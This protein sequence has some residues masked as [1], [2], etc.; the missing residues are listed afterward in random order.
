MAPT[1]LNRKWN[2]IGPGSFD[3]IANMTSILRPTSID[4]AVQHQPLSSCTRGPIFP[5]SGRIL[6][7]T[8]VLSCSALETFLFSLV[9]SQ[10]DTDR[11]GHLRSLGPL[12]SLEQDLRSVSR[13][14]LDNSS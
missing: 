13:P 5:H 10:S 3:I 9:R 8:R 12:P 2:S 14:L 7:L 6:R 1:K 11:L 4:P